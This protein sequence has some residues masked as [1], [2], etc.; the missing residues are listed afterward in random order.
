[1]IIIKTSMIIRLP[2]VALRSLPI[3]TSIKAAMTSQGIIDLIFMES[4][5]QKMAGFKDLA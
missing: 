2:P 4:F 5:T 3:R 1:M